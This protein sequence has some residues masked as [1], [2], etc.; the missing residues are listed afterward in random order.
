MSVKYIKKRFTWYSNEKRL[1]KSLHELTPIEKAYLV[2]YIRDNEVS[3][4][5]RLN[6]GVRGILE[7]KNILYRSSNIGNAVYG[8]SYAL[9]PWAR[10]YLEK[11]PH[12]LN[13][14]AENSVADSSYY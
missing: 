2:P 9:Q 8:I 5:F 14:H 13:G 6:D 7:Q 3:R 4:N 11:S 12:L 1:Q 10:R